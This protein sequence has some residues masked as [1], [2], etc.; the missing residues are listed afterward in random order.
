[1][2]HNKTL[3]NVEVQWSKHGVIG[4]NDHWLEMSPKD[5]VHRYKSN[6]ALDYIALRDIYPGEELVSTRYHHDYQV[7]YEYIREVW[8]T[9]LTS[10]LSI[11]VTFGKGLGNSTYHHGK[12]LIMNGKITTPQVTTTIGTLM[13][14]SER[15]KNNRIHHIQT[16]YHCVVILIFEKM[17][18]SRN[19]MLGQTMT[20]D[21]LVGL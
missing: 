14:P 7:S 2:N 1:M 13:T 17:T 15:I 3:V 19:P 16:I 6:L 10:S 20:E 12:R 11:M 9:C 5:M 18:G 4:H 8:L 21:I